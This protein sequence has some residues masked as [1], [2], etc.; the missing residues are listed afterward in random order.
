MAVPESAVPGMVCNVLYVVSSNP[1][2]LFVFY[3]YMTCMIH[4]VCMIPMCIN[5]H[6]MYYISMHK[7][8]V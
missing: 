3:M 7:Y 5:T 1:F 2:F 4:H 6:D 8:N